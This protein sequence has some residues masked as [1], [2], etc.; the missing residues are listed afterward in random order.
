MKPYCYQGERWVPANWGY[1]EWICVESI[2]ISVVS[3]VAAVM[4]M[5]GGMR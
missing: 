3:A 5:S 1:C 2:V 4:S